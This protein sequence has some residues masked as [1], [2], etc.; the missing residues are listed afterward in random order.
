MPTLC[1]AST[2]GGVAK[3]T[4]VVSLADHWRRQGRRVVALDMDP[5]KN[6]LTWIGG[7][8]MPGLTVEPTTEEDVIAAATTHRA[9]ADL[10]IIDVAGVLSLGMHMAFGAAD[11]VLIPST[12]SYGD[13]LEAART[14]E[15]VRKAQMIGRREIPFTAV[16]TRAVPRL[17]VT[18]HT[19]RQLTELNV[20]LLKPDMVQRTAYQ[21]AWYNRCSPLDMGDPA[22]AADIAA[23]AEAIDA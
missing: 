18:A 4:L 9:E 3:T 19:R 21:Q 16:L 17:A 15:Q 10:V 14:C 7:A 22:V 2:K 20:P 1:V 5:N 6:L 11:G 12:T 23:I 13:A 8:D